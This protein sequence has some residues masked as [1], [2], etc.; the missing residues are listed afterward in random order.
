MSERERIK[1]AFDLERQ[2]LRMAA[3]INDGGCPKPHDLEAVLRAGRDQLMP[4][5]ILNYI[6]DLIYDNKNGRPTKSEI[7]KKIDTWRRAEDFVAEINAHRRNG[8]SLAKACEAVAKMK[9][10]KVKSITRQYW[11]ALKIVRERRDDA[12]MH[13]EAEWLGID[14][15]DI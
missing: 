10:G 7:E 4:G 15:H 9:G 11:D 12:M 3:L 13:K 8:C 6:A 1:S 5:E 2:K 14:V